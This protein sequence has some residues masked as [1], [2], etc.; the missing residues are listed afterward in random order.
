MNFDVFI[1]HPNQDKATADAA[2]AILEAAGIRCWIAPRDVLPGKDWG[3]AIIEAIEGAKV[4]VLIFSRHANASPQIKRE[5]ERAV[6]KGISI[7]TVRIEEIA[8]NKALEY[9][10]SAPHWLDAFTPPLEKHL[11]SLV[12]AVE[13]L[14]RLETSGGLAAAAKTPPEPTSFLR[15][16]VSRGTAAFKRAHREV[17]A[18]GFSIGVAAV[19]VAAAA[20][21]ASLGH[22]QAALI[23]SAAALA[24]MILIA[25]FAPLLSHWNP[26]IKAT[27]KASLW[28]ASVLFVAFMTLSATG[29]AARK[30]AFIADLLGIEDG[31]TCSRSTERLAAFSCGP[32]SGDHVV[33][34]IRLDDSDGGLVVREQ[35]RSQSIGRHTIPPNGTDVRITGEC[36][37]QWCPVECKSLNVKGWSAR[38]YLS[39]RADTLNFVTGSNPAEPRAM[40]IRT[41]PHHTCRSAGL[42]PY[43]SRDVILHWCQPSPIDGSSWCR[44]TFGGRSGWIANGYLERQN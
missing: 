38:R 32:G 3:E 12:G 41:G 21:L 14:L 17:W 7:I 22:V 19:A 16:I 9:F 8:P 6:S 31:I 34:S 1:S 13:A 20:A 33:I 30:P 27:G 35:A 43:G 18:V 5:V 24:A 4:M 39:P 28:G 10:I 29:Y 40:N 44:V 37:T 11:R 23:V 36:D 2:C 15:A 25:L 26:A 42:L